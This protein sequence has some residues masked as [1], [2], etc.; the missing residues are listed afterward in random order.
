MAFRPS[1]ATSSPAAHHSRRQR[2]EWEHSLANLSHGL[3]G[4]EFGF[5]WIKSSVWAGQSRPLRCNRPQTPLTSFCREGVQGGTRLLQGGKPR[6]GAPNPNPC[7]PRVAHQRWEIRTSSAPAQLPPGAHGAQ[8]T[9]STRGVR[10]GVR[11][12]SPR[13]AGLGELAEAGPSLSHLLLQLTCN[14]LSWS[15]LPGH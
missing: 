4:G 12:V 8:S 3:L 5:L 13:R 6:S 14:E 15:Q 2:G 11:G 1:M 7:L 10:F 9:P